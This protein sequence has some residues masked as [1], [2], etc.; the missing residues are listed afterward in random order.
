MKKK[1]KKLR[2]E[3]VIPRG[4]ERGKGRGEGN[5]DD[6]GVTRERQ[7]K[8]EGGR[9]GARL[10]LLEKTCLPPHAKG[11]PLSPTLDCARTMHTVTRH[12]VGALASDT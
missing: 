2:G 1:K 3:K 10:G 7:S 6:S 8:V 4:E 11:A 5:G 9:N 12:W